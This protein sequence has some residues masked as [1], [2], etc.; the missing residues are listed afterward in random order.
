MP[1]VSVIIPTY[2]RCR[3]VKEAIDS[4]LAQ[5]FEDFEALVIDDGSTDG[6]AEMVKAINDKRC[7]YF[8][9]ENGGV[10]SA[11]NRGLKEAR[12]EYVAFL[13]SDDLW[14]KNY[15]QVMLSKLENAPDYGLAYCGIVQNYPD[16]RVV[17][18]YRI[19]S[20][21]SG[22]ITPALFNK[23]FVG[24]QISIIRRNLLKDFYFDRRYKLMDDVDFFLRLSLCTQ[25]LHVPGILITR[26]VQGDSLSQLGGNNRIDHDKIILLKRFYYDLGGKEVL[27]G[28][29][30]L[31]R[32]ARAYRGIASQYYKKGARKAAISMFKQSV[33]YDRFNLKTYRGLLKTV[34]LPKNSDTMPDWKC[35]E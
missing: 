29:K 35:P 3:L 18:G 9:K 30:A 28:T 33:P 4:V 20:V 24:C 6:T 1:K 7:Q 14:P 8:Y 34:L 11:R 31:K 15:L 23:F 21:V 10:A 2:N 16:G 5:S 13:D 32:I 27:S 25:F 19:K 26:R 17:E 12:G 22:W